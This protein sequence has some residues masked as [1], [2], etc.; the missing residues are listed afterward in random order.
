MPLALSW[1]KGPAT[2]TE[3][4]PPVE[5]PAPELPLSAADLAF[6]LLFAGVS[7]KV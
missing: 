1:L 4:D 5:T 6:L 7:T 2:I 3:L